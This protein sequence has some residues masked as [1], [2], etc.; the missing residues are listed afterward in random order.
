M[1]NL[2]WSLCLLIVSLIFS[3]KTSFA[4]CRVL[5]GQ[6]VPALSVHRGL[7][8]SPYTTAIGRVTLPA[9]YSNIL[10][11]KAKENELLEFLVTNQFDSLSFYD[12]K[13]IMKNTNLKKKLSQFIQAARACGVKEMNAIGAENAD[14]VQVKSY[15]AAYP[16]KFDGLLTEYEFWNTGADIQAFFDEFINMMKQM[17]ALNIQVNGKPVKISAYLGWLNR[18]YSLSENQAAAIIAQNLDRVYLH[19]YVT[20]PTQA[21]PYCKSRIQAFATANRGVEIY[22]IFSA[23][24]NAM[25]AGGEIFMGDWFSGHS[26]NEAEAIFRSQ[27]PTAG[28]QYYEYY[29]LNYYLNFRARAYHANPALHNGYP[30][31]AIPVR[32]R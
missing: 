20:N 15:Q 23:E 28:Y 17:K 3:L 2:F 16:G 14:W 29:F 32:V 4:A 24:G 6:K 12:L 31:N 5:D 10:G 9:P 26:L 13:N 18:D 19:C 1:R 22:P 25:R 27:A 7:Y 30:V 21:F 11:D 8:F